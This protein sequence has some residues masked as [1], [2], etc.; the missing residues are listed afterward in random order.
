MD[1]NDALLNSN[2]AHDYSAGAAYDK[3]ELRMFRVILVVV[4]FLVFIRY[5]VGLAIPI[6]T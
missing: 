4:P 6:P 1:D 2:D 5:L 3:E